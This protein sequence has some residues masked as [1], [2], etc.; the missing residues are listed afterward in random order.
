MSPEPTRFYGFGPFRL[1]AS[2]RQLFRQGKVVPMAPKTAEL[3]VLLVRNHGELVTKE[4]VM[5][6]VWPSL[7]VED[8]NLAQHISRLRKTLS[9]GSERDAYI[10]T[11]PRRGYRFIAGVVEKAGP[12]APPITPLRHTVGREGEQRTLREALGTVRS[13]RGRMVCVTGEAGKGKT[14]VVEDF[15]SSLA[16]VSASVGRGHCSERLAGTEVYLPLLEALENLVQQDPGRAAGALMKAV[17]PTWY[18]QMSIRARDDA[19]I[20]STLPRAGSQDELKRELSAF[21]L[22]LTRKQ[23]VV[24]FIEDVHWASRSTADLLAHLGAHLHQLPLMLILTC[25]M[26]E[27]RQVRHPFVPVMQE[28]QAR[29]DCE[30]LQLNFLSAVDIAEYLA[31]EFPGRQFP[32]GFAQF[33]HAR[34]EGSPLFVVDLARHAAQAGG[35]P[36]GHLPQSITALIERKIGQ[37]TDED[38]QLLL[39]ASVQGEEFDAAA[40]ADASRIETVRLEDRLAALDH[41]FGLVQQISEREL[42]DGTLTGRYRFVHV[43]Y[44]NALYASL[45][46]AKKAALSASVGQAL[47][48]LSAGRSSEAAA[49]LAF[50]FESARDHARA[51]GYYVIA[52]EKALALFAYDDVEQLAR[53]GLGALKSVPATPERADQEL[54]LLSALSVA[55]MSTKGFSSGEVKDVCLRLREL[56]I[57]RDAIRHLVPALYGLFAFHEVRA[58]YDSALRWSEEL[59]SLAEQRND[60]DLLVQGHAC[61]GDVLLWMGDFEQS[62]K[63]MEQ[64]LALDRTRLAPSA[65]SLSG[66]DPAVSARSLGALSR[67]FLGYPDQAFAASRQALE[68]ARALGQ[69]PTLVFAL[70]FAAVLHQ[71]RR[72]PDPCRE[73]ASEALRLCEEQGLPDWIAWATFWRG[74]AEGRMDLMEKSFADQQTLGAQMCRSIMLAM[75]ADVSDQRSADEGLEFARRTGERCYEAELLRL[76]GNFDE[77]IA[78]ARKQKAKSLELRVT[79]SVARALSKQGRNAQ[80]RTML[81]AIRSR[82]TEGF[83]TPDLREADAMSR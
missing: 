8:T 30:E 1:D 81:S 23:P 45:T 76:K 78:V 67:W 11:I 62:L 61:S 6:S 43:L 36:T 73:L 3:L 28:L 34:T 32:P 39:V 57:E 71:F 22:E 37:L 9:D 79:L 31:L 52:A 66:F 48:R 35:D 74:W 75:V 53:R 25:R 50:L 38:R 18:A 27:L 20:P 83:D 59:L 42:A 72:E 29:G 80:A 65:G 4:M 63:H 55:L 68:Q 2:A 44:Q 5:S 10:E 58:E 82:F 19:V 16:A 49:E 21:F 70:F 14:T 33:L 26:E 47:I 77:A 41:E 7:F 54:A 17:A 24:V 51:A 46:P 12:D 69:P 13:G 40:V 56:G 60:L 15:L 64:A